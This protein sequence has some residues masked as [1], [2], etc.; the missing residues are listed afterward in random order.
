MFSE[1]YSL[2]SLPDISKWNTNNV[3]NI[4]YMFYKCC[5]LISLPDISKWN[6]NNVANMFGMFFDCRTLTSLLI[7]QNGILIM[8]LIL[9]ICFINV[10]H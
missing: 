1:C 10:V 8:L 7:F 6:T 5:S 2:K 3:A 4:I 9:F